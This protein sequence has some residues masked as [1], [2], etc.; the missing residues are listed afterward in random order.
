M[1]CEGII[2]QALSNTCQNHPFGFERIGILINRSDINFGGVVAGGST[3]AANSV[4]TMP[5][6]S[7]KVG[8]RIIQYGT[9]PFNGTKKSGVSKETAPGKVTKTVQFFVPDHDPEVDSGFIDAILNGEFVAILEHKDKND[10]DN[11]A[12]FEIYG[13]HNGLHFTAMEQDEYSD[14]GSGWLITMEETEA[15]L[16]SFYL[17]DTSYSAT[18]TKFLAYLSSGNTPAQ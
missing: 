18:K 14:Y 12:A 1:N 4:S 2:T 11:D 5:L 3:K 9:K 6:Q 16:S 15:P 10:S 8:Y 7:G 17:F 13:F